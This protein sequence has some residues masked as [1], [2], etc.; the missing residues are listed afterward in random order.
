M[1]PTIRQ[2]VAALRKA[3]FEN[4]GRG[5]GSHRQYVHRTSGT[6]ATIC[7][8]DGDDA[9]PYLIKHVREKIEEAKSK[10]A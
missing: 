5:K 9:K 2:L 7:G 1:P 3:G 10:G 8:H 6:F 4:S